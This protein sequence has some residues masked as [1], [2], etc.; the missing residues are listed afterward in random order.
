MKRL[1]VLLCGFKGTGK[2]TLCNSIISNCNVYNWKIYNDSGEEV[3]FSNNFQRV[4]FADKV[5]EEVYEIYGIPTDD[6]TKDKK[7]YDY[8]DNKYIPGTTYSARDVYISL[9]MNRK[10]VDPLYWVKKAIED[11]DASGSNIIVTDWRFPEEYEYLRS[12]DT[13]DVITIRLFRTS[14]NVTNDP[15]ENRLD[16]YKTDLYALSLE[17]KSDLIKRFPQYL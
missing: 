5:K 6:S 17:S 3:T 10:K 12:L 8:V 11:I 9:A 4:A 15:V 13:F 16:N 1:I 2:D 14:I 7:Q